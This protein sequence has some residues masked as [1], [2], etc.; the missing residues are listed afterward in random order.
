VSYAA[1]GLLSISH[2]IRRNFIVQ[3]YFGAPSPT[4]R[5]A[6]GRS[7]DLGIQFLLFWMPV[8]VLVAWFIHKPLTL[9]FDLIEV[10]TLLGA[11]FLVNYVTA[12]AKTNWCEG[13]M[14]VT[15]YLMI[16]R[17]QLRF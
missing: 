6:Q 11:C 15:F 5:L 10:F 3:R 14:M 12:D 4:C 9:L 16:V 8:L 7:I 13:I 1:D 17:S 2:F